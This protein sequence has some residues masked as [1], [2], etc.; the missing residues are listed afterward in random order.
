MEHSWEQT[1]MQ[2]CGQTLSKFQDSEFIDQ[3]KR[4]DIY[5]LIETHAS[6]E[7]NNLV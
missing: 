1:Y 4:F 2:F 6:P 5:G 3:I 7:T